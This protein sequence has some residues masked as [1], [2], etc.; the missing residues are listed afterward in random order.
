MP[1]GFTRSQILVTAAIA[2]CFVWLI[3]LTFRWPAAPQIVAGQPTDLSKEVTACVKG[4]SNASELVPVGSE[5]LSLA[6]VGC[7]NYVRAQLALQDYNIRRGE[8]WQQQYRGE[9]LLWMVVIITLSG[10]IL[11][12]LQLY[13]AYRLAIYARQT[14]VV[15]LPIYGVNAVPVQNLPTPAGPPAAVPLPVPASDALGSEAQLSIEHGKV[16]LRSSVTG[17]LILALSLAFFITYVGWVF[18]IKE[19]GTAPD[20]SSASAA[21]ST[22]QAPG[23]LAPPPPTLQGM[24]RSGPPQKSAVP[25]LSPAPKPEETKDL[26]LPNA[27]QTHTNQ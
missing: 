10:V 7:I 2:L 4:V 21:N 13:A 15:Q 9:V 22:W 25:S 20:Q 12:A 6:Q 24:G 23:Q 1:A 3:L 14:G 5:A 26:R 18:P 17:L 27:A 19:I 8:F 11:A 16:S